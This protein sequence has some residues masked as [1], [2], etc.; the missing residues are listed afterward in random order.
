MCLYRTYVAVDTNKRCSFIRNAFPDRTKRIKL[1]QRNLFRLSP[2]KTTQHLPQPLLFH[3]HV[4]SGCKYQ[5]EF[6]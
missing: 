1:N 2:T 4:H 5:T 3:I 6:S